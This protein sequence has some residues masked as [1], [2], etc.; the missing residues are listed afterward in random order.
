MQEF[1]EDKEA[2]FVGRIVDGDTAIINGNSTRF[3]G[4]NTPEKGERYYQEAK[5]FLGGLILNKTVT[6][7][8]GAEKTD[9]YGRKLAFIFLDGK[10][11]NIEQV[12]N[13]FA[14]VYVLDYKKYESELRE[15]WEECIAD[16]RNLCERSTNECSYCIE[17]KDLDIENQ[18]V[19]LS[20][21]CDFGCSLN[22]WTIKDEGRKKFTFRNFV[23]E[24]NKEA[25]IIVGN[26][27]DSA[28]VLYWK[29]ETYVWTATGDTLFL[30][31][32]E[33]KLVLWKEI[34]K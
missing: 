31:D 20:N 26:G 4:I 28:D 1:L 2:G 22:N 19:I 16:G 8:Y 12:R 34:R 10:N 5:D 15:A 24:T 25:R 14:N 11:I 21:K 13:G 18:E 6:L 9:L 29:D 17:L 3:L 23:L 33:G 27:T 30:R 32:S 7:E